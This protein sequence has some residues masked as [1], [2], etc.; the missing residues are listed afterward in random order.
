MDASFL[1]AALAAHAPVLGVVVP[2]F[3]AAVLVA[4]PNGRFAWGVV[5]ASTVFALFIAFELV[6]QTRLNGVVSYQL[7][8]WA[9]PHGIEFRIDELNSVI[10]L[11]IGAMGVL[12]AIFALPSV[13]DEI[14]AG[15]R[16]LFYA[17]FLVCFSGLNGVAL[18]GDAF[19]LFV[20]LEI[21]SL[22]TYALVAMGH[23][24]DRQA[25]TASFNYLVMG[26]IGA[27]FFVIGVGFLYMAT[28]TLNMADIA[29]I[30]VDMPGNRVVEVAFAFI[31]VG[32]GLKAALFPLHL[33]L[34][35][36]YSFAPN[37]V[38]VFLATTATKVAFYVIIRFMFDV[39]D[40]Q[41]AF[42]MM[43]LTWVV[44]PLAIAG[45]I[46][47]SAQ[48]IFQT[49]ARRLLAYSSV[50][51]VG[52]MMLGLGMGTAIGVSAGVLHLLNHALMK[53]ALFMALGA[54]AYSYGVRRISDFSG[55]GQ[56]LPGVAAAFTIGALSLIGVPF[57][58]GFVSKFYL[59]QA[60]LANGWWWAVAA[61]VFSSVLAVFYVYRILVVM[62]VHPAP[63]GRERIR[64]VPLMILVPLWILV[65][66]NIYFGVHAD[67]M[68]DLADAAAQAAINAEAGS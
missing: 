13:A 29:R 41:S 1:P 21:S 53:G 26:T 12:S 25:L 14:S 49:D 33:W 67:F 31:L 52:Y 54:F 63:D 30:V 60:A 23:Q 46:L 4:V 64:P 3:M 10:V 7:G 40:P 28:G 34:P 62:W 59:V 9:P 68:V 20:F 35:G 19:N 8:G 45:M 44:A 18:T 42:V 2:L 56:A 15:K 48:A 27:T 36:A 58:V 66:A 24:N 39:F 61:I 65:A 43:S 47:A 55:L 6:A 37:F 11:L 32:I 5:L 16:G 38:T 50:A 22:G 57:T 17:A 51:Q